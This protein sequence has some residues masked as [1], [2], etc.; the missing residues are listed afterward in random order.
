MLLVQLGD[1]SAS[2]NFEIF[3]CMDATFTSMVFHIFGDTAVLWPGVVLRSIAVAACYCVCLP[4]SGLR[5]FLISVLRS[6]LFWLYFE[7]HREVTCW[8][9]PG[10]TVVMFL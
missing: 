4:C 1:L 7:S 3:D 10:R 6:D 9:I 5:Y 2:L 8:E